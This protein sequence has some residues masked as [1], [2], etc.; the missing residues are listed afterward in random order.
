MRGIDPGALRHPLTLQ[1]AVRTPDGAGGF[2]ESWATVATVFGKVEPLGTESSARADQMLEAVTHRVTI[3]KRGDVAAGMR[4]DWNG[5]VLEIVTAHDPDETGR[6][7]ECRTRE[8][9]G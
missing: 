4:F 3:R 1:Q 5:R 2:S 7:L 9:L 8:D 6:F